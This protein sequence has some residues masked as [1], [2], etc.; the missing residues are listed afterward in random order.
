[1]ALS[2]DERALIS[3]LFN[4][5]GTCISKW[6]VSN[7]LLR[8]CCTE[9]SLR[10]A[11]TEPAG[12]FWICLQGVTTVIRPLLLREKLQYRTFQTCPPPHGLLTT[13]QTGEQC[14][15]WLGDVQY[16]ST[17]G[18]CAVSTLVHHVY[19]RLWP[20]LQVKPPRADVLV[21]YRRR[22]EHWWLIWL[23]DLLPD[24]GEM[25]VDLRRKRMA[26]CLVSTLWQDADVM[27]YTNNLGID[28]DNRLNWKTNTEELYVSVQC[29]KMLEIF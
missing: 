29:S 15:D 14:S 25:D 23:T 19:R 5:F 18:D 22:T 12:H 20:Q 21:M 6:M 17:S 3:W 11:I 4:K 9:N 1:M 7:I 28:I 13:W 8:S 27:E 16:R 26:T 24:T 10:R 2:K